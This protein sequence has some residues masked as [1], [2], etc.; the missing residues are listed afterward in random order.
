MIKV[1]TTSFI[2][3]ALLAGCRS[4]SDERHNAL[5]AQSSP[6]TIALLQHAIV[7]AKGGHPVALA[8]NVFTKRSELFIDH[9][10]AKGPDGLPILGAHNLPSEKFILQKSNQQCSLYYPKKQLS[11]VLEEVQCIVVNH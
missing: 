4:T 7:K 6:Q 1:L 5:L 10:S 2:F 3:F 9:V 11:I 8:N